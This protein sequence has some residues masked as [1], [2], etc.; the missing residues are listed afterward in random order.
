MVTT[1]VRCGKAFSAEQKIRELKSRIS[2]LKA[3]SEKSKTKIPPTTIIKE[4][5]ENMN[6][7]K[8]QRYGVSSNNIER[9]SVTSEQFKT[10]FNPKRFSK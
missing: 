7:I 10:L 6:N 4:L 9:K 1:N 8:S 5:A 3:I 2:K